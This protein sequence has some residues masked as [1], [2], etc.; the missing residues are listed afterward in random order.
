ML[1]SIH[2]TYRLP[3]IYKYALPSSLACAFEEPSQTYLDRFLSYYLK[4]TLKNHHVLLPPIENMAATNGTIE[5]DFSQFYNIIDGKQSKTVETRHGINP[6]TG[7]ALSDVPV[8]TP[9]D[10]DAAVAAA[11]AA[12]PAWSAK[13]WSERKSALVSYADAL[14]DMKDEFANMLHAE[15]GK[16]VSTRRT[17]KDAAFSFS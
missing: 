7:E 10:V 8:S 9:A 11:K 4:T 15:Q 16:P 3:T 1:D 17:Q 6:A 14:A 2:G 12:F 13:P 5:L